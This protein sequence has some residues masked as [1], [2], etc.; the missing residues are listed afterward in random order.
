MVHTPHHH[1]G[2]AGDALQLGRLDTESK[3]DARFLHRR[4]TR[5][6][7]GIDANTVMQDGAVGVFNGTQ[8]RRAFGRE[9]AGVALG[10]K[11]RA[12][13]QK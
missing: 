5:A 1:A 3:R 6:R 8:R 11:V 10:L 7:A 13:A 9:D 2:L 4:G 12:V